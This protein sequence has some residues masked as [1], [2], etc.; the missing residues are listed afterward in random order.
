M[1]WKRMDAANKGKNKTSPR[2]IV[3]SIFFCSLLVLFYYHYDYPFS[4]CVIA[5]QFAHASPVI[6][7]LIRNDCYSVHDVDC[8][9]LA[10][11]AASTKS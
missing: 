5:S 3:S 8:F 9:I 11:F 4:H 10:A 6:M 7:Y 1:E 2:K